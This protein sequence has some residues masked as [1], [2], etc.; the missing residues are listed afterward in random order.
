MCLLRYTSQDGDRRGIPDVID[1][2]LDPKSHQKGLWTDFVLTRTEIPS[3]FVLYK[4]P[5]S[6]LLLDTV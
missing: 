6:Y 4:Q 1:H 3:C 5:S 2:Y